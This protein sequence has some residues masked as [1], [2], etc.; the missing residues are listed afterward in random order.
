MQSGSGN[1]RLWVQLNTVLERLDSYS[2][3][4]RGAVRSHW[5][6]TARVRRAG[7]QARQHMTAQ[8]NPRI[9]LQTR[10]NAGERNGQIA[11]TYSGAARGVPKHGES[12]VS[13]EVVL[14][15][16]NKLNAP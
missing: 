16:T 5:D 13:Q 14:T 10:A 7:R 6:G 1:A 9:K 12:D 2:L 11:A 8:Y 15:Y 4:E 3:G